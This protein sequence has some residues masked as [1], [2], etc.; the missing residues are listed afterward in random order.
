MCFPCCASSWKVSNIYLYSCKT[1]LEFQKAQFFLLH[2]VLSTFFQCFKFLEK[3]RS[4]GEERII[5]QKAAELTV[6]LDKAQCVKRKDEGGTRNGTTKSNK[7][8]PWR[9]TWILKSKQITTE[10]FSCI[11]R[12]D[13]P[14]CHHHLVNSS[15]FC[16]RKNVVHFKTKPCNAPE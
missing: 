14:L 5:I 16:S 4:V 15:K 1:N 13:L 6:P 11:S 7:F 9:M 2:F 10:H 3:E 12:L 8:L